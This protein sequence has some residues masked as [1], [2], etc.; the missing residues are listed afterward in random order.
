M[1]DEGFW[2]ILA[3]AQPEMAAGQNHIAGRTR[4]GASLPLHAV[5]NGGRDRTALGADR[6]RVRGC[7]PIT[8]PSPASILL[9]RNDLPGRGAGPR[10]V[11]GSDS[12]SSTS[13][14][15][16]RVEDAGILATPAR[17]LEGRP[18]ATRPDRSLPAACSTMPPR[19]AAPQGRWPAD[20]GRIAVGRSRTSSGWTTTTNGFATAMGMPRVDS[21]I[22]GRG[23]KKPASV[24]AL[25]RRAPRVVGEGRHFRRE[26]I[27]EPLKKKKKKK[28]K[29]KKKNKL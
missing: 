22:F 26:A 3:R 19:R 11:F 14:C 5:W 18:F 24:D 12:K 8:E 13:R 25:E 17:P 20:N 2:R 29:K 4:G 6:C 10:S 7:C 23:W 27:I 9:K 1:V 21:L 16:R 15:F 28:Y